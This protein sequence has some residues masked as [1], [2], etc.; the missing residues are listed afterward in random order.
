MEDGLDAHGSAVVQRGADSAADRVEVGGAHAL[1]GFAVAE[2][3]EFAGPGF[4]CFGLLVEGGY[5]WGARVLGHR[6]RLER[7]EVAVQRRACLGEL[8]L[9][10]CKLVL[11]L[12]V[13]LRKLGVCVVD[14]VA[15]EV[16][17]VENVP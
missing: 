12:A 17:V 9:Y 6:A 1:G 14:R 7:A 10:A 5:A 15:E 11:V 4:E 16:L 13:A 8:A 2:R 3:G